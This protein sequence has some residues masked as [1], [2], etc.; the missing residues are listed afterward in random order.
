MVTNNLGYN[1]ECRLDC[2]KKVGFIQSFKVSI[3]KGVQASYISC[4]VDAY[5]R[6]VMPAYNSRSL[7][8]R[9]L[10]EICDTEEALHKYIRSNKS[11]FGLLGSFSMI[12]DVTLRFDLSSGELLDD[13]LISFYVPKTVVDSMQ[14]FKEGVP[15]LICERVTSSGGLNTIKITKTTYDAYISAFKSCVTLQ[16]TSSREDFIASI[17][18]R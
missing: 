18:K 2:N 1:F 7:G 9:P 4:A 14:G 15:V 10:S 16:N 13:S 3:A 12:A 5:G 6:I 17:L 11:A 8:F